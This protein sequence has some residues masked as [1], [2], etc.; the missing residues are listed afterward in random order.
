MTQY[1]DKVELQRVKVAAAEWANGVKCLH[2]HQL[3]SMWY[4]EVLAS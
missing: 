1:D 3:K 2:A 4:R